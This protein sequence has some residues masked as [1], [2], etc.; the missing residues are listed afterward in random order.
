MRDDQARSAADEA[1]IAH[2]AELPFASTCRETSEGALANARSG[3]RAYMQAAEALGEP[4][5]ESKPCWPPSDAYD[6]EIAEL[7]YQHRT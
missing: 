7:V 3:I 6:V 4:I 1:F 5:S 2:I